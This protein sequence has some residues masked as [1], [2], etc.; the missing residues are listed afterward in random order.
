VPQNKTKGKEEI[1]QFFKRR[2]YDMC[3]KIFLGTP[4]A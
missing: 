4:G 3:Q 2:E 1:K